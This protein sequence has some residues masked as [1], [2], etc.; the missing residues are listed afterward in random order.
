VLKCQFAQPITTA[1]LVF[2]NLGGRG[3]RDITHVNHGFLILAG[4]IGDGS[5]SYQVYFWDGEDCLPDSSGIVGKVELLGEVP[6]TVGMK[7]EGL[8]LLKESASEYEVMLV[9]DTARNGGPTR[10]RLPKM[11]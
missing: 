8:A 3:F 10:F 6:P 5:E 4:P 7:A 1:E 9:Y 11:R 2:V